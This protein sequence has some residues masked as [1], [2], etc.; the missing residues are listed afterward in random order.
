VAVDLRKHQVNWLCRTRWKR[1]FEYMKKKYL[2]KPRRT[3]RRTIEYQSHEQIK[4]HIVCKEILMIL[5]L[6]KR[7]LR[8]AVPT[9]ST[10]TF[11]LGWKATTLTAPHADPCAA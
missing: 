11:S 4:R 9:Q 8:S 2:Q 7:I 3:V 5:T 6:N 1:K 10:G